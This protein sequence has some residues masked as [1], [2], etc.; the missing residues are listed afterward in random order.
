M[1][2]TGVPLMRAAA[3]L[4]R[5][6]HATLNAVLRGTLRGWQDENGRWFVDRVDLARAAA[7]QASQSRDQPDDQR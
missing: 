5:G 7:E 2:E 1:T 4:Q 3:R 6:Y